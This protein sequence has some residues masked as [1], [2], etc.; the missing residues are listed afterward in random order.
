MTHI[1]LLNVVDLHYLMQNNLYFYKTIM[2]VMHLFSIKNVNMNININTPCA[3]ITFLHL[4]PLNSVMHV[5]A[6]S[7]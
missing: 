6:M 5:Y 3:S 7:T 4:F 2:M 1:L